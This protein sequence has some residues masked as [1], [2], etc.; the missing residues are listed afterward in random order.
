MGGIGDDREMN[1]KWTAGEGMCQSIE[2]R[3]PESLLT[4]NYRLK[5]EGDSWKAD[6]A[7]VEVVERKGSFEAP[8]PALPKRVPVGEDILYLGSDSLPSK[9]KPGDELNV[10]LYWQALRSIDRSYK[11]FVHVVGENGQILT[12]ADSIP[13]AGEYR[14]NVWAPDEVVYDSYRLEIPLEAPTGTY[15]VLTG[16]Y[17]EINGRRL[18]LPREVGEA[19]DVGSLQISP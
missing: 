2:T 12:Q 15:R 13:L 10:S 8:N 14:T 18:P 3:L 4:G 7:T 16:M 1:G 11:V 17:D 5:I 19:I 6:L 9:L